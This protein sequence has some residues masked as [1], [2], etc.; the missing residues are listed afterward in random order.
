MAVQGVRETIMRIREFGR[1]AERLA[2]A[3]IEAAAFQIERDAKRLAPKNFGRLAQSI[4]KQKVGRVGYR[5]TVNEIYGVYMEFGT[6]VKVKVPTEFAGIASQFRGI[7][8]GTFQQALDSIKLWCRHKGIPEEAAY[9]ILAK[10]LGAGVDPQPFLYPAFK[11]G[12]KSLLRNL[13]ALE[14]RLRRRI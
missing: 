13:K 10:I 3:E 9:P 6:G 8:T 4:S 14:R 2:A 12:E 1:E 11:A 7:R 5:I